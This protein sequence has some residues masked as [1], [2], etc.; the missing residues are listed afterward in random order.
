MARGRPPAHGTPLHAH[1]LVAAFGCRSISDLKLSRRPLRGPESDGCV[2][3]QLESLAQI[4]SVL[5][6]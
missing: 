2:L 5:V 6:P 3:A 4:F 1:S